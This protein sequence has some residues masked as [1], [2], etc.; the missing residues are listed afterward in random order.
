MP[1]AAKAGASTARAVVF[2]FDGVIVRGDS[3]EAFLRWRLRQQPW[4]LL[5]VL[6]LLPFVPLLLATAAGKGWL[7]RVFTRVALVGMDRARFRAAIAA[8]AA[9][10]AADPAH[11][12]A[13][14][15]AQL[16]RHREAGDRVIVCSATERQLL[17]A[18]LLALG[19]GEVERIG[20]HVDVSRWGLRVVWHN[21]GATKPQAL[22]RHCALRRWHIAYSDA[23]SDLPLLRGA[24]EAAVLVN[25]PQALVERLA[26]RLG[27]R[28]RTVTWN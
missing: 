26:Q 13:D 28:L 24:D 25:A 14:A 22:L 16:R 18:L 7:A 2:D 1:E 20:S 9:R 4:R 6:P 17:T 15:L 10:F 5:P 21:Y 12:H 27:E 8:F 11:F 3:F 19:L 23:W